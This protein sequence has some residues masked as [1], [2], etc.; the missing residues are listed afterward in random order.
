MDAL[1]FLK[2]QQREVEKEDQNKSRDNQ[3]QFYAV[4]QEIFHICFFPVHYFNFVNGL[5]LWNY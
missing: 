1:P 3:S 2:Q 5:N 4:F